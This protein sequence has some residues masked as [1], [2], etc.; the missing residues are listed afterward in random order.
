MARAEEPLSTF[1]FFFPARSKCYS[2]LDAIQTYPGKPQRV[3]AVFVP[4]AGRTENRKGHTPT[5]HDERSLMISANEGHA[6]G[7]SRDPMAFHRHPFSPLLYVLLCSPT[8]RV[9]VLTSALKSLASF[10]GSWE[11][12][13]GEGMVGGSVSLTCCQKESSDTSFLSS[14]LSVSHRLAYVPF[15]LLS[16]ISQD[17]LSF[18]NHSLEP[19]GEHPINLII[20]ILREALKWS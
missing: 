6:L 7:D 5:A 16:H 9:K 3:P 14:P 13:L 2:V 18:W 17:F 1:V 11:R 12:R 10:L 4:G 15:S 19:L 8:Q 20:I